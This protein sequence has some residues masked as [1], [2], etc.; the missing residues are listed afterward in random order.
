[1]MN[2]DDDKLLGQY[3]SGDSELSKRYRNEAGD[4]TPPASVDDRLRAAARREVEAGPRRFG[5]FPANWAKP[6]V[7]AAVL[8][9]AVGVVLQMVEEE[10]V[11]YEKIKSPADDTAR[12]QSEE[13]EARPKP[14]ADEPKVF[15][16]APIA[17]MPAGEMLNQAPAAALGRGTPEKPRARRSTASD[18]TLGDTNNPSLPQP[19]SESEAWLVQIR[20]L[21]EEGR[22]ETARQHL[23]GY[24]Q[25][26]PGRPVPP[27]LLQL[28]DNGGNG[29]D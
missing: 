26:F 3:L 15:E 9:L 2:S 14:Q 1:M 29:Q 20:R 7:A 16:Y 22:L 10:G 5:F 6:L 23:A 27:A 28:L 25:R 8:V 11:Y 18:R 4:A 12:Q 13:F 19:A 21:V 17:E 24:R